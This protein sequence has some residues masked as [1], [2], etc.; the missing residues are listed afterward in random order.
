MVYNADDIKHLEIMSD[1]EAQKPKVADVK[2]EN[3]IPSSLD[4][5]LLILCEHL[6]QNGFDKYASNLEDRMLILKQADVHMYRVHDEDGE[7]LVDLAHP[8][9]DA[10]MADAK[11]KNGD[12]ETIVSQHKKIVDVITKE[13]NGK[14]ASYVDQCKIVLGFKKKAQS[15]DIRPYLTSAA[16]LVAKSME[17]FIAQSNAGQAAKSKINNSVSSIKEELTNASAENIMSALED[18]RLLK[19]MILTSNKNIAQRYGKGLLDFFT[20]WSHIGPSNNLA[21]IQ[22]VLWGGM[23]VDSDVVAAASDDLDAASGMLQTAKKKLAEKGMQSTQQTTDTNVVN[24]ASIISYLNQEKDN[25]S[26]TLITIG[27]RSKTEQNIAALIN[28]VKS[29]I[30]D[31]DTLI[32]AVAKYGEKKQFINLNDITELT[33]TISRFSSIKTFTD[34]QSQMSKYNEQLKQHLQVSEG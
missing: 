12:V 16:N 6:R 10:H 29:F 18:V 19:G 24:V 26:K 3:H 4:E 30:K 9:G 32:S 13:P 7:D 33:I 31:L 17:A 11:D 27:K 20:D 1:L 23:D 2:V 34:L 14:L 28:P 15:S 22:G 21:R 8:D 5:K 25:I